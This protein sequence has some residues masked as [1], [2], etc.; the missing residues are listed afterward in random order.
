MDPKLWPEPEKFIPE[1]FAPEN[2]DKIV[3][4]S[5]IPFGQGQRMCLGKNYVHVAGKMF[6]VSLLRSF[7]ILPGQKTVEKIR[8]DVEN[9]GRLEGGLWVKVARRDEY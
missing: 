6:L 9:F 4:G 7:K 2:K 5:L 1:R 8:W 3:N